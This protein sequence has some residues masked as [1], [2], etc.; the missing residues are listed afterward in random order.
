MARHLQNRGNG[1]TPTAAQ[2]PD[3]WQ[4]HVLGAWGEIVVALYT[5]HP[6]SGLLPEPD[7]GAPDVGPWHVRAVHRPTHRL[8]VRDTDNE[9]GAFVLVAPL[10]LP[11]F[12]VL[13]WCWGHE[14][15]TMGEWRR[16]AYDRPP[17]WAVPPSALRPGA[18]LLTWDRVP[19]ETNT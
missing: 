5:D 12:T 13:G 3:A 19:V 8:I 9:A 10:V 1:R 15:K 7:R 6:W 18:D 14:A 2:D 17:C 4:D 11:T 16:L